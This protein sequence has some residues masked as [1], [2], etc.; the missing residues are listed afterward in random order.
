[1]SLELTLGIW[2]AG[3]ATAMAVFEFVKHRRERPGIRVRAVTVNGPAVGT[4]LEGQSVR[5]SIE[6]RTYGFQHA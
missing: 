2:G 3:L 4:A 5:R 1:M 6:S